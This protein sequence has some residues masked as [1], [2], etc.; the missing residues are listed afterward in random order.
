MT[1]SA[2]IP[3]S[4]ETEQA[5][6][7]RYQPANLK[8]LVWFAGEVAKSGMYL[9]TDGNGNQVPMSTA[10]TFMVM[11]EGVEMGISP[12][13]AMWNIYLMEDKKGRKT[14]IPRAA[15]IAARI[16]ADPRTEQWEPDDSKPGVVTITAKRHN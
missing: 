14:T 5:G 6:L 3:M 16:Q 9:K 8:Q 1:D 13:T 7:T 12:I 4:P 15:L 11:S 10:E 2:L